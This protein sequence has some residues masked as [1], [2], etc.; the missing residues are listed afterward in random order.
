MLA[1]LWKL[2][3]G[4]ASMVVGVTWWEDVNWE[5]QE[6]GFSAAIVCVCESPCTSPELMS[7]RFLKLRPQLVMVLGINLAFFREP[8]PS[9]LLLSSRD[10]EPFGAWGFSFSWAFAMSSKMPLRKSALKFEVS[11]SNVTVSRLTFLFLSWNRCFD[12]LLLVSKGFGTG[13]GVWPTSR[14]KESSASCAISASEQPS[15]CQLVR[16]DV[17]AMEWMATPGAKSDALY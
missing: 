5:K 2:S 16:E 1:A 10:E 7:T 14:E 15:P 6:F 4:E 11:S 9:K 12:L 8:L 3:W 17:D 13:S